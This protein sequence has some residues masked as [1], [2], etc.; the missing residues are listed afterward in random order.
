MTRM[1]TKKKLH[2]LEEVLKESATNVERLGTNHEIVKKKVITIFQVNQR[3][4]V[5]TAKR[6]DTRLKIAGRNNV[7][8][9]TNKHNKQQ[10]IMTVMVLF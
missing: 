9:Q 10:R 7:T 1:I 3:F 4:V 5:S 6:K 2:Y 8:N